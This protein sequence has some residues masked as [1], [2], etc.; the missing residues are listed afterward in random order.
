M[1]VC[2]FDFLLKK[3]KLRMEGGIKLFLGS[4]P[5]DIIYLP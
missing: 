3:E 5:Y 2:W 4:D 1:P